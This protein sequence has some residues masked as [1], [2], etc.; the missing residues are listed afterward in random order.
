MS[1]NFQSVYGCSKSVNGVPI[2]TP[3]NRQNTRKNDQILSEQS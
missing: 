1:F 3:E 2:F